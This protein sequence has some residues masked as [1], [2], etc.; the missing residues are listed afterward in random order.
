VNQVKFRANDHFEK[1][2]GVGAKAHHKIY[3]NIQYVDG[4]FVS[5]N[6]EGLIHICE[7]CHKKLQQRVRMRTSCLFEE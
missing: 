3:L 6:L 4:V 7:E 2:S 5:I 1:C